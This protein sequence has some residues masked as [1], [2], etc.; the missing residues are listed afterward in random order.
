MAKVPQWRLCSGNLALK[1]VHDARLSCRAITTKCIQWS[2]GPL[3][4]MLDKRYQ[5]RVS[6]LSAWSEMLGYMGN[7]ILSSL[8]IRAAMAREQALQLD[9]DTRKKVSSGT[10]LL[11]QEKGF[12]QTGPVEISSTT[13]RQLLLQMTIRLAEIAYLACGRSCE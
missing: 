8:F 9:L 7:I 11:Q 10:V 5:H 4:G 6:K 2:F 3:A 13:R 12:C 1:E